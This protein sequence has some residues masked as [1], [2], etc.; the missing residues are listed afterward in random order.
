[1]YC[2]SIIA[3]LC[4]SRYDCLVFT[5]SKIFKCLLTS[6][7]YKKVMVFVVYCIIAIHQ[8]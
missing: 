8:T 1:M 6:T 7:A 4:E 2:C 5:L 3:Q